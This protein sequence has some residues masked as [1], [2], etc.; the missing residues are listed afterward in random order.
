MAL[1]LYAGSSQILFTGMTAWAM[2]GHLAL[3]LAWLALFLRRDR[4]GI[5]GS[6]VVGFLA[7]GLH[8]PVFHPLFVLP[9][10]WL[11]FRQRDWRTLAIYLFGY[12]LICAFWLAWPHWVYAQH[13]IAGAPM[14][15]AAGVGYV[16]RLLVTLR[17]YDP[18]AALSLMALNLIRFVTWQHF[19]MMPLLIHGV[20]TCW[21]GDKLVQALAVGLVLPIIAMTVLLPYQGLGWGYRYLH[22]SL[23][24]ACLLAAFGWHALE[25]G[26]VSLR[27]ALV[28]T[29]ALTAAVAWPLHAFMIHQRVAPVA[30][31]SRAIDRIDADV[32]IIADSS[33]IA[34]TNLVYNLPDL[35]NRPIRLAASAIRPDQMRQLCKGRRVGFVGSDD[36]APIRRYF[37]QSPPLADAG[38]AALERAARDAGCG[39][40]T[41]QGAEAAK[42][43][44]DPGSAEQP[45]TVQ[46][47]AP[48][49]QSAAAGTP[50][51]P[52]S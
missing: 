20:R 13:V 29:S 27:R 38:T 12:A 46:V 51:R 49:P 4:L 39:P 8:Q 52:P 33:A 18:F 25:T 23:G 28:W 2:S 1:I 17:A 41:L 50:I 3:N 36:L 15:A 42:T 5:A 43:R 11:L 19:L 44:S 47:P 34:G 6:L 10:L 30:A 48:Y 16:D 32:V 14:P 24:N 9:F 40:R 31:I 22:G 26:G 7:T 35:S 21:R 45:P 37:G